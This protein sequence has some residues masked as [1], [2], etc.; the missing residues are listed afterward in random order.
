MDQIGLPRSNILAYTM[1]GFATSA[2]TLAQAHRLMQAIGCAAHEIDIR[3]SSMQMLHDIGHPYANGV[4]AY[5]ITFEN[6]QAG[7]RTSHLFRL[8]NLH[9][10]LVVGTSDLS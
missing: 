4:P 7:E 9:K 2:R 5:D 6:V 1:P 8:A 3:P 10:A